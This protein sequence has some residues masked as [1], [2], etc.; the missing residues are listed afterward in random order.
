[1]ANFKPRNLTELNLLHYRVLAI[2][3]D[4]HI[5]PQGAM[6]LTENHEVHRNHA[7]NGLNDSEAF[8][9]CNYSHFRNVQDSVKKQ[10][11]LQDDAVFNPRFLDDIVDD[12][13]EG[14]WSI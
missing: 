6:R 9:L 3:N 8:E 4:C 2:E 12:L 1:M 5:V 7:F 10:L 13:P 14:V 11:L